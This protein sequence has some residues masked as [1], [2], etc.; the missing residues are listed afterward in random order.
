MVFEI[1]ASI[2]AYHADPA[3]ILEAAHSFLNSYF[4]SKLLIIIDHSINDNLAASFKDLPDVAYYHHPENRGFGAGHNIAMQK[5]LD[6]SPY[7]LVLNPDVSFEPLVLPSM[8]TYLQDNPRTAQ[9]MPKIVDSK[10]QLQ[11]LAKL[12]PHPADLFFKR[13]LPK[14]IA[15]ARLARFQLLFTDYA[16][17]MNVPYLSGCFMLLRTASLKEVGMFDERFFMYP[18]DMDLTRRLHAVYDTVYYPYVTIVHRHEASSYKSFKMFRI[19]LFN[20]IKYFNK[21]GWFFDKNRKIFNQRVLEREGY[22]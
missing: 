12:L 18:E 19:H 11:H 13:F 5:I 2:V 17:V 21:W 8:I 20:L 22:R 10:G 14:S 16:H 4:H 7:H 6:Q 9:M 1:T 15:A 3:E